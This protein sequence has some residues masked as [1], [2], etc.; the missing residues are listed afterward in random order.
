MLFLVGILML[1]GV[2]S[3]FTLPAREDPKLIIRQAVVTTVYPG[4]SADQVELLITKPLEERIVALPNIRDIASTSMNGVSIIKPRFDFDT[5]D[6][7]IAFENLAETVAETVP[8]LPEGAHT[9]I[10]NDDFGDIAA[11]TL[12]LHGPDYTNAELAEYAEHVRDQMILVEGTKKVDLLGVRPERIFVEFENAVLSQAGI[13][14]NAIAAALDSEN[15]IRP[16]GTVELANGSITVRPGGDF[17]DIDDVRAALVRSPGGNLVRLGDIAS[18][19]RGYEDPAQRLAYYNNDETVILAVVMEEG[20]S[21]LNYSAVAREE[22]ERIAATLPV[23]LSLD[24][25]TY[26]ATKVEAAVYGVTFN[27]LQTLAVVLGIVILFLGV[28]TGL[29]V[30]AIIPAVILA[31]F[32]VMGAFEIALQRMSLATIIISLGLLVDNGIVIAEDFKRRVQELGDRDEALAQTSREL[33]FPLLV[34]SLTTIAVFLPLLIAN[35]DSSEYTRSI[36]LVVTISL[37]VSYVFAMTVTTTLCYLFL[38]VPEAGE[39]DQYEKGR[40]ARAFDRLTNIYAA[41]LRTMLGFR[42]LYVA[43]MVALFAGAGLLQSAIPK[44]FFPS[45]NNPQVL[46]YIELASGATTSQTDEGVRKIVDLI[47]D[48]EKFPE[49]ED[50]AAYVGFGG[51][52]FVLSLSPV[53]PA[54]NKGFIVINTEDLAGAEAIVPRLREVFSEQVPD[55]NARV[56]RMFLGPEDPKVI[57]IQITGPDADYINARAGD[58]MDMLAQE[59]NMIDIWSDWRARTV[60]VDLEVDQQAARAAGVTSAD[61]ALSLQR[62]LDGQ[63]VSTFREGDESFPIVMRATEDER[64]SIERLRNSAVYA[65]DGSSVPLGQVAEL[66]LSGEWG[67]IQREDL[68]RTVTVEGRHLS[69]S[70]DDL[71]PQL[72][73][74]IDEMNK[75]LAPGHNIK[76]AGI[77]EEL[78][79]NNAAL[80]ATLPIV[81]GI[82]FFLL[83]AQFGDFR[84]PLVIFLSLPFATF[85]AFFGLLVMQSPFGFMAILSLFALFGIIINNSIVLVDRIDIERNAILAEDVERPQSAADTSASRER[86]FEAVISACRRRFRPVVMTTLTTIAGLLPLII[87]QDVLFYGFASSVAFGLLIGTF[88]VSLGITPVLYC[89]FFGIRRIDTADE[90]EA[91]PKDKWWKR[92]FARLPF[93]RREAKA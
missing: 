80:V 27:M 18:V 32:A 33:A 57:R 14:P 88:V 16:G 43:G 26:E 64:T 78:G 40:I 58:V 11:M 29:I 19:S 54:P 48:E 71:A 86:E 6:L 60:E 5:P 17:Q 93:N 22:V 47:D 65:A 25:V 44:E 37:G 83:I 52:R 53:D 74:K 46:V 61:I 10:V 39:D 62:Q 34:S 76:I 23:G 63:P 12:A 75:G 8:D 15:T 91:E 68:V 84:R 79:K 9:P 70:P 49:V 28:R 4:L 73:P 89:L 77:L 38:K 20:L 66:T 87:A 42:W 72:Q 31:T 92:L 24:I 59:P 3:Y 41:V 36:S 56:T 81:I 30:G 85:G 90:D 67:F 69:M 51:P 21:I 35:S 13:S 2:Y 55:V 50:F 82:T 45:N 1:F 7:E